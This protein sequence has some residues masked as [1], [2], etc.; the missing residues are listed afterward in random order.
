[1]VHHTRIR[2]GEW[3]PGDDPTTLFTPHVLHRATG[4]RV[5]ST[6]SLMY[7]TPIDVVVASLIDREEIGL[8]FSVV[9][10]D[11]GDDAT[12]AITA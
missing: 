11:R 7:G 2:L 1:M 5:A 8:S 6:Y 12:F 3:K 10:A 4:S 9:W